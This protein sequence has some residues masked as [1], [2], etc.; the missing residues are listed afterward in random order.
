MRI[1]IVSDGSEYFGT[2][3]DIVNG[4][5]DNPWTVNYG[6]GAYIAFACRSI[7]RWFGLSLKVTGE[8]D[9][10]RAESF[11]RQI[12][13]YGLA[14]ALPPPGGYPDLLN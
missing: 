11:V 9:A 5:R 10:L 14:Q 13:S 1:R 4:M 6:L 8:T 2:P 3:V 7:E 12:L